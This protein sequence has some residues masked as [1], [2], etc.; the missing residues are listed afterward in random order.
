MKK[1]KGFLFTAGIVLALSFTFCYAEGEDKIAEIGAE[2]ICKEENKE[3]YFPSSGSGESTNEQA[4]VAMAVVDAKKN[5]AELIESIT[6][7]AFSIADKSVLCRTMTWQENND[8]KFH[9]LVN[10]RLDRAYLTTG[11]KK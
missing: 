9:T 11:G 2:P 7:E 4:A 1:T 3:K 6:S 8:G 5:L 10:I